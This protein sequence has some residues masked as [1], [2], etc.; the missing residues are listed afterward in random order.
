MAYEIL[1]H[2]QVTPP[3]LHSMVRLTS[4]LRQPSRKDIFNTLQPV[5]ALPKLTNQEAATNVFAAARNCRL[6]A[7]DA[8]G[9]VRLQV[10]PEAVETLAAFRRYMQGALL[11][12]TDDGEDNFLLNL[13]SA[14]YAAQDDRV[15]K[16][17]QKDFELRFNEALFPDADE[18]RFNTTKLRGWRAW[19]A[20]L[21]HGW[22]LDQSARTVLVPD[23]RMRIEPLLGRLLPE[24]QSTVRL[25]EFME[26]LGEY[27]P[28]LDGGTLFRRCAQVSRTSDIFGN[29]LSLMLSNA[30][31]GLDTAGL[32]RLTLQ[33]DTPIKWRLYPAVGHTHQQVSHIQLGRVA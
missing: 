33:A 3:R 6:L 16:F 8:E 31:R 15:F 32:L 10:A 28:E 29:R 5:E 13:Y 12:V 9:I 23:A 17:E 11:H 1:N 18:R 30:L 27:C 24:Q 20:F 21:G 19:A 4:Q 25:G 22:L 2:L 7:E 14:W 26:Q